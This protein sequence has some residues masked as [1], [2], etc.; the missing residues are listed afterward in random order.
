M[1]IKISGINTASGLELCDGDEEIYI[2]SLRLFVSN[3]PASLEKLKNVTAENLPGYAI[4][5]HGVKGISQYV[6]ADEAVETAKKLEAKAKAGNLAEVVAANDAF[7]KYVQSLVDG[8]KN[9]L[10]K[11]ASEK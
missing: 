9:W 7:L 8:I 11:N 6:G 2:R 1:D 3:I 10:E 4:T 5:V